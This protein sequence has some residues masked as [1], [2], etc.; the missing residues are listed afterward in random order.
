MRSLPHSAS[1]ERTART[2]ERAA[3]LLRKTP[4]VQDVL[5]LT[6][7]P[8]SLVRSQPCLVVRLTPKD[9]RK[10]GREQ[11][12]GNVRGALQDQISEAVFRLSVP[13]PAEGFPVYGFPIEFAIE[14]RGNYGSASL[15]ECAEAMVKKMSQSGRFS[16][17]GVGSGLRGVPILTMEIDR[18]K[19]LAMGVEINEVF[20]TLQVYLGSNYV[21][22]FNQF[23]RTWQIKLQFDP[24]FP[25]R[26]SDILKLQVKNKQNQMVQLGTVIDIRDNLGP[27]VIERHNLYPIARITANRAEGTTLAQAQSLCEALAEQEFGTKQFKLIWRTR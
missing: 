22:N 27:M 1:A 21:N 5:A 20:N 16:D 3:E 15:Q 8:F 19:C 9:Q 2:L 24:R 6:E 26:T 11:I 23:G 10:L 18:A 17:V 12:A 7:H 13:S 14:D 4:G 25:D